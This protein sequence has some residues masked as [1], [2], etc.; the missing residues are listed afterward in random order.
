MR[1][2]ALEGCRSA[3]VD[4]KTFFVILKDGTIYPVEIVADG[5]AVSKLMMASAL[6]QTT[7]PSVILKMEE[8][9]L[10]VGSSVGPS[11]LLKAAHVEEAIEADVDMHAELA[12][13]VPATSMEIDDDDDGIH[14]I[15]SYL[16]GRA[17][18]VC[19]TDIYGPSKADEPAANGGTD[20]RSAV[21]K[22]RT[23]IHL[24]ICDSVAAYGPVTD[25]AFSL[26]R[27]GVRFIFFRS[28][29]CPGFPAHAQPTVL[30]ISAS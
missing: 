29:I 17:A 22:T 27:N 3:F 20:G 9:H 16:S 19:G 12:T 18:D 13:V 21:R 11:I 8:D 10:F 6:A 1:N 2:L 14:L 7:I 26:A 15:S 24:S 5:K 23:V 30:S 28:Y 25:L 4:D